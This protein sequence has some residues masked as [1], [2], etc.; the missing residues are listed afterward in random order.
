MT[1]FDVLT[2]TV[3]QA[4][5]VDSIGFPDSTVTYA[6]GVQVREQQLGFNIGAGSESSFKL[7][8]QCIIN[9]S[10]TPV[11]S[12]IYLGAFMDWDVESG[13]NNVDTTHWTE[14]SAVY[15]YDP[16][17]NQSSYGIVKLPKPGTPFMEPGGATKTATGFYSTYAVYNPDEVYPGD[18]VS[19]IH[20]YLATAGLN[21]AGGFDLD[22]DM[23]LACALDTVHLGGNDTVYV[24]Y[25]V[26]GWMGGGNLDD[27]AVNAARV[28]NVVAGFK[29][30]DVNFDNRYDFLD[31]VWL[32]DWIASGGTTASPVPKAE[33]GDVNADGSVDMADVTYLEAFL[34]N[35]GPAP[36]GSWWW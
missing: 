8:R 4:K 31:L 22:D 35:D 26:F 32:Y 24:Q 1:G 11:D 5:Y 2:G 10:A 19:G 30:G 29:R 28:A 6:L 33:Q 34:Y 12:V 20:G 27:Q 21:S 13:A 17:S 25:A 16:S 23:S 14:W 3:A 18:L 7:V 15:E 36:I 9:R